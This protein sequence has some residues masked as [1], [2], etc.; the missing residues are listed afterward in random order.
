M[1]EE[2]ALVTEHTEK[3]ELLNAFLS[4]SGG[5]PEQPYTPEA[6]EEVRI[7]EDFASLYEDQVRDQ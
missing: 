2:G 7:K 4:L 6:A 5:S 3:A 1:N